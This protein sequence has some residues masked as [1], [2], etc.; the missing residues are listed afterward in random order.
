MGK[1]KV[2]RR[3]CLLDLNLLG[4]VFIETTYFDPLY[5]DRSN[6]VAFL[7]R[8]AKELTKAVM[9]EDEEREYLAT[10][11]IAEYLAHK[12]DPRIDGMLFASPQTD[13]R[14]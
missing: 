12:V 9:P 3:I 6:R 8:L 11:V 10:Q 5:S 2:L 4:R 7:Q 13:L 1:F 14:V